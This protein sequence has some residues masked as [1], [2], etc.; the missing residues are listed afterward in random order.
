[1]SSEIQNITKY[2]LFQNCFSQNFF[3]G[4]SVHVPAPSQ[5][6]IFSLTKRIRRKKS[7]KA[8][9]S[10]ASKPLK[11]ILERLEI[12]EFKQQ[13]FQ[14][15]TFIDCTPE[16]TYQPP[17]Y[18]WQTSP[19]IDNQQPA[20][21]PSYLIRERVKEKI[22]TL[23]NS[24]KILNY[25]GIYLPMKGCLKQ[26]ENGFVYLD[27]KN[28]IIFSL[29]SFLDEI[30]VEIPPFFEKNEKIGAH[31]PVILSDEVNAFKRE[32]LGQTFY[33]AIKGC[34]SVSPK[35]WDGIEK[36]WFLTISCPQ[37]EHLREKYRLPSKI[38]GH[39]FTAVFGI[40]KTHSL[41]AE[42]SKEESFL[43]INIAYHY[44]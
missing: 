39:D 13:G 40:R 44:A 3:K 28:H 11:K 6:T 38:G 12:K 32:D 23:N 30:G 2:T 21:L 33:F 41:F 25:S 18:F 9:R 35:N 24:Q 14:S 20:A 4:P 37:L 27:L 7:R 34:Y 36:V 22:T 42:P 1:M 16:F 5:S 26:S 43:R 8:Y 10:S 31:I 15:K 29:I 19:L 17:L